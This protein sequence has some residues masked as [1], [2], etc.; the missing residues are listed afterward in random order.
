[1]WGMT[2]LSQRLDAVEDLPK[3]HK[4]SGICKCFDALIASSQETVGYK[5]DSTKK[6]STSS[7]HLSNI[8]SVKFFCLN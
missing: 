5:I 1:M 8:L 6:I 7:L 2:R 4:A 3:R